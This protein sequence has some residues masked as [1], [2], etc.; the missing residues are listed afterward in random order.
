MGIEQSKSSPEL[1]DHIRRLVKAQRDF[2]PKIEEELLK[3]RK[4]SCWSWYLFPTEKAGAND[5]RSVFVKRSEIP[6]LLSKTDVIV[7]RWLLDTLTTAIL[8]KG[9]DRVLPNRHDQGR[10]KF[11]CKL[12][13][14]CREKPQIHKDFFFAVSDLS[15]ALRR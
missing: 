2:F 4:E 3:G 14:D 5:P 7:W 9:V 11:F 10:A 15:T 1:P 13:L 8:E 12:F 6:L